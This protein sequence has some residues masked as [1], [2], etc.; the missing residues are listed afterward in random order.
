MRTAALT[1]GGDGSYS[2]LAFAKP[3]ALPHGLP[4]ASTRIEMPFELTNRT[5]AKQ[6]YR[7]SI[8]AITG[9]RTTELAHGAA[10]IPAA[11]RATIDPRASY[12]CRTGGRVRIEAR[13]D[14]GRETIGF[15]ARCV[16]GATP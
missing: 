15:W 10:Q 13:A 8:V 6:D 3:D 14:G 5:G 4:R 2:E 16:T 9:G 1:G 7:W 12:A 11:A